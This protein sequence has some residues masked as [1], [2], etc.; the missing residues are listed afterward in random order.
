MRVSSNT[1]EITATG[2]AQVHT[3]LRVLQ[4]SHNPPTTIQ[5]HNVMALVETAKGQ[6]MLLACAAREQEHFAN[7]KALLQGV[8]N[9]RA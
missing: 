9:L 3:D 8:F 2:G 6:E 5:A 4:G 7:A 1:E